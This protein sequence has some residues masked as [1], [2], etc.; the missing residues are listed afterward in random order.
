MKNSSTHLDFLTCTILAGSIQK[1]QEASEVLVD[2]TLCELSYF[3][4]KGVDLSVF[5]CSPFMLI[6]S[7]WTE[8]ICNHSWP[9]L[10]FD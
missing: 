5:V 1:D 9:L 3:Y 2:M 10:F 8:L 4:C 6:T 7:M